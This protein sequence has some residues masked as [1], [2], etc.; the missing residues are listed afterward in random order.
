M[1]LSNYGVFSTGFTQESCKHYYMVA[2]VLKGLSYLCSP[3]LYSPPCSYTDY[4]IASYL[5]RQVCLMGSQLYKNLRHL[6]H[7]ILQGGIGG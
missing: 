6:G 7:S 2:P 4:D 3:G 5:G 1:I